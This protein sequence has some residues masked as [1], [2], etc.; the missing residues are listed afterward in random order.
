MSCVKLT[1]ETQK[2]NQPGNRNRI[3]LFYVEWRYKG[4]LSRLIARAAQ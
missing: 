2:P 1:Y 3:W 4:F